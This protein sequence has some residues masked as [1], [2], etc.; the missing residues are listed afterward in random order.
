MGDGGQVHGGVGGAGDGGV[1][2]DGVLKALLGHDVLGGDA[3]LDQLHQ[4]LAGIVGGLL[5]LLSLIHISL[6]VSTTTSVIAVALKVMVTFTSP[7]PVA[8]PV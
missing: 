7:M 5:Q 3:L 6:E 1:H 2:H 4:L 8:V